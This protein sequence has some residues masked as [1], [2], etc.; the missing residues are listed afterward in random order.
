MQLVITKMAPSLRHIVA[1]E[2]LAA[3][4][5][6]AA[7][8]LAAR[9][10]PLSH[11]ELKNCGSLDA[12]ALH[13]LL[14]ALPSL[15]SLNVSQSEGVDDAALRMLALHTVTVHRTELQD[16]MEAVT[17]AV[18]TPGMLSLRIWSCQ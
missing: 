3:A 9:A 12:D 7:G 17:L 1:F 10:V 8:P 15:H 14:D 11:L 2:E 16:A 18:C 5:S 6:R 13:V 4:L